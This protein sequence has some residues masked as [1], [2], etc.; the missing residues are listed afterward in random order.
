MIR[1]IPR[2]FV[3]IALLGLFT[4]SSQATDLIQIT[5][6]N[7]DKVVPKGKEIDAIYGDWVLRND[8]VCAVI[9]N[10][11]PGR[12]ANM[13]VR[14]VGGML[15]DFTTRFSG[16]DQLSCFYPA[17]GRYIFEQADNFGIQSG[18]EILPLDETP[19][20]SQ[21]SITVVVTG[22]PLSGDDTVAAVRYSLA[23]DQAFLAYSAELINEGKKESQLRIMDSLRCDGDLF[24]TGDL[25]GAFIAED[26][27]FG[28]CYLF[29]IEDHDIKKTGGRNM[30]LQTVKNEK[31]VVPAGESLT[32]NGKVIC[33]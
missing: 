29:T 28:Q 19:S 21:E 31:L 11:T 1:F 10:P 25:D 20:V 6:D 18:E 3:A 22:K 2:L 8:K 12:K 15:I 5:K 26:V 27:Y 17:G 24:K 9:A 32:W 4:S 33:A 16:S 7:Y 23:E 13:T 14:G 30:E